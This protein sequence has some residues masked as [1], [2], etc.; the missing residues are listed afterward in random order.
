MSSGSQSSS[1]NGGAVRLGDMGG[2]GE[3]LLE[4]G[5]AGGDEEGGKSS[6]SDASSISKGYVGIATSQV[7]S[8]GWLQTVASAA[9]GIGLI[10]LVVIGQV[11]SLTII[12]EVGKYLFAAICAVLG[13][14]I[15]GIC[16]RSAY[17]KILEGCCNRETIRKSVFEALKGDLESER[18]RADSE[19]EAAEAKDREWRE[20]AEVANRR[21]E[22]M[23]NFM[24]N[25]LGVDPE[26]L[27]LL[28]D[29]S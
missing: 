6:M 21:Q 12:V 24:H 14:G 26:Q 22:Y 13:L 2:I 7:S 23:A 25:E 19:R 27:L 8:T 17:V 4:G 28:E 29:E 1:S 9:L 11:P 20:A 15:V 16:T 10:V 5:S 3:P 18:V